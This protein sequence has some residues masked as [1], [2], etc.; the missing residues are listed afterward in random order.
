MTCVG[1]KLESGIQGQDRRAK[2]GMSGMRVRAE[3][4]R[5]V[6]TVAEVPVRPTVAGKGRRAGADG[7]GHVGG[8]LVRATRPLLADQK[9]LVAAVAAIAALAVADPVCQAKSYLEAR[10]AS[11][12]PT[13]R[14]RRPNGRQLV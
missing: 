6:H 11:L 10:P 13:K 12:L 7:R 5:Q 9:A 2:Q 4:K 8:D 14:K 1:S 3:S